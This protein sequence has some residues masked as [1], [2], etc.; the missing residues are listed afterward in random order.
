MNRNPVTFLWPRNKYFSVAWKK[1]VSVYIWVKFHA[2]LLPRCH[3]G[4]D[5]RGYTLV[6]KLSQRCLWPGIYTSRIL[7][8]VNRQDNVEKYQ[9][10]YIIKLIWILVYETIKNLLGCQRFFV[11]P[12]RLKFCHG[13][14]HPFR[15]KEL[16]KSLTP[17]KKLEDKL[18]AHISQI[19]KC[20]N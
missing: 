20:K 10:Q 14:I 7:R 9:Q 13:T 16:L 3:F 11:E 8:R 15:R 4:G 17:E 2:L 19:Q 18:I 6:A 5:K 1:C 12:P